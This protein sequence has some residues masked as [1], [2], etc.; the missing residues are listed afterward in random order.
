MP[1]YEN[2]AADYI[3]RTRSSLSDKLEDAGYMNIIGK[4]ALWGS[5]NWKTIIIIILCQ[6]SRLRTDSIKDL[7]VNIDAKLHF[8]N[9]VNQF[10]PTVLSC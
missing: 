7:R 4:K 3:A 1:P 9:H 10:F 5:F 6:F 2:T 8:H